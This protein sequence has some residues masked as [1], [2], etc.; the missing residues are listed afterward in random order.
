MRAGMRAGLR[1]QLRL[2]Q[3]GVKLH[4]VDRRGPVLRGATQ[5]LEVRHGEV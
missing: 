3:I 4:L 5:R 2:R 1:E